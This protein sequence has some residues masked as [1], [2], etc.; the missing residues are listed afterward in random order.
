MEL[1]LYFVLHFRFVK[2]SKCRSEER[3]ASPWSCP[4][5]KSTPVHH[6]LSIPTVCTSKDHFAWVILQSLSTDCRVH[7]A[8]IREVPAL[9]L[10]TFQHTHTQCFIKYVHSLQTNAIFMYRLHWITYSFRGGAPTKQVGRQKVRL[11]ELLFAFYDYGN[12]Y[13]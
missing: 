10:S 11:H 2:T 13:E 3:T 9:S 7:D 1:N 4:R 5:T 12:L 6:F 8:G